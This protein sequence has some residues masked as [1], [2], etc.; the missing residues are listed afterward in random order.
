MN[1]NYADI[2]P[3]VTIGYQ[4][5]FVGTKRVGLGNHN[6]LTLDVKM[7][8]GQ[9]LLMGTITNIKADTAALNAKKLELINLE[10]SVKERILNAYYS[11]E[12]TLRKIK[13]AE[14]ETEAANVS[15][16]LSMSSMKA[17]E[18]TFIDV[19]ES[20]NIKVRANINLISNMIEYN[21]AQ[22]QLLF[23]T[24]VISPENVLKDYVRK[25]Y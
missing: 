19:I 11:S 8:L 20:Q 4:N 9:N 21:K 3:D 2:I 16:D 17:G 24:G 25:Y 6:S 7:T 22:S 5:G 14:R 18:A 15:F 1:L 23:E 10:R 12:N 13:E